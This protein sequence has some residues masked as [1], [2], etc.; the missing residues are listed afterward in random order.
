MLLH[1]SN[2]NKGNYI[3]M[4]IARALCEHGYRVFSFDF[5]GNGN[6]GGDLSSLGEWETRDVAGALLYLKTQGMGE[7]GV[8]GYSMGA[9]TAL[10]AASDHPEIR[11]IV[12]DSAFARLTTIIEQE[13]KRASPL[14]PL[15]NPGVALMCKLIYGI[16]IARN[17][18][19]RAIATLGDH[20]VLLIHSTGDDLIPLSEAYELQKAG[21]QN[22]NLELWVAQG[23]G[24]VSTFADNREEYLRRVIEFFDKWL[25]PDV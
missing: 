3:M 22:P 13:G 7:V 2:S 19:Q 4:E 18:P 17:S 25:A 12:S 15:F 6:S 5:R 14:A 9:A 20:P 23:A 1:G 21:S 16:D 8:I 10:L 11:A 24:H